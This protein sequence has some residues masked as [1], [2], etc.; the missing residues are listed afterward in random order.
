MDIK[1]ERELLAGLMK[2][3]PNMIEYQKMV[4]LTMPPSP[5]NITPT[6]ENNSDYSARQTPNYFVFDSRNYSLNDSLDDSDMELELEVETDFF[7]HP[8]NMDRH[9]VK[10]KNWRDAR[11]YSREEDPGWQ[12]QNN[13]ARSTHINWVQSIRKRP[14]WEEF[15]KPPHKEIHEVRNNDTGEMYV[16]KR[17]VFPR[18]PG[19]KIQED[20][21]LS[22]TLIKTKSAEKYVPK[23]SASEDPNADPNADPD[24]C[25]V[26]MFTKKMGRVICALRTDLNMLQRELGKKINVDAH[27]I[28]DIEAGDKVIFNPEDL[29]V[30]QLA[31]ALGLQGIKWME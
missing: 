20:I 10:I 21:I 26:K 12:V 28:R 1:K 13:R 18:V 24:E 4:Q 11:C 31:K 16:V 17:L 2:A 3:A 15:R 29:M 14:G 7:V 22:E 5:V 6:R 27:T 30:K 19:L 25:N 9:Q 23:K 8:T